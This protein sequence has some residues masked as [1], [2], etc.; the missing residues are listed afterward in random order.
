MSLSIY[1][2]HRCVGL[3]LSLLPNSKVLMTKA[4]IIHKIYLL[5]TYIHVTWRLPLLGFK[6]EE[7]LVLVGGLVFKLST[8]T[9][10]E[11]WDG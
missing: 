2:L 3:S 11:H 9:K 6:C 7:T 10:I 5:R 1:V 4:K 8:S